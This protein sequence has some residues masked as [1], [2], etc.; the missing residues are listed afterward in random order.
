MDEL[1][2]IV[3]DEVILE[4]GYDVG[5]VGQVLFGFPCSSI[6]AFPLDFVL[7]RSVSS[8]MYVADGF[9]LVLVFLTFTELTVLGRRDTG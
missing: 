7:G 2:W 4:L 6:V 8:G 1:D 3:L 9:D 5:T